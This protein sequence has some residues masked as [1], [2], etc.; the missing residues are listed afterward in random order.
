MDEKKD[1]DDFILNQ[2]AHLITNLEECFARLHTGNN[3]QRKEVQIRRLMNLGLQGPLPS[4]RVLLADIG[5][6][7]LHS[8]QKLLN[9]ERVHRGSPK[10]KEGME[11]LSALEKEF[12]G[13][14][15]SL[16]KYLHYIFE[17]ICFV[18]SKTDQE[19]NALVYTSGGDTRGAPSE[20]DYSN[21]LRRVE[22]LHFEL[23][24]VVSL[25]AY[26]GHCPVTQNLQS[27]MDAEKKENASEESS[28]DPFKADRTSEGAAVLEGSLKLEKIAIHLKKK[29]KKQRS[30]ANNQL[31]L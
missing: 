23:G 25:C 21:L 13:H 17:G 10:K 31:T 12:A 26:L 15:K 14:L 22:L 29:K 7:A 20:R 3:E 19:M 16:P 28:E 8:R 30:H 18:L 2:T 24:K 4:E 1:I 5:I 6:W 27:K 9:V 11:T